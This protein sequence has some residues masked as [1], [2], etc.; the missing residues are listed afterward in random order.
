MGLRHAAPPAAGSSCHHLI[1]TR[2]FITRP[3]PRGSQRALTRRVARVLPIRVRLRLFPRFPLLAIL[4]LLVTA[5]SAGKIRRNDDAILVGQHHLHPIGNRPRDSR[6]PQHHQRRRPDLGQRRTGTNHRHHTSIDHC[7]T[8][9]RIY[10]GPS[11]TCC[12]RS[13]CRQRS[14][15][16][17][18]TA[19]DLARAQPGDNHD[20]R[21]IG[22]T[23][24]QLTR[25]T[26]VEERRPRPTR[27]EVARDGIERHPL[28][29]SAGVQLYRCVELRPAGLQC[30]SLGN[31]TPGS[32][33]RRWSPSL[34]ELS[35]ER[36]DCWIE[37]PAGASRHRHHLH[38]RGFEVLTHRC[39][40]RAGSSIESRQ[41]TVGTPGRQHIFPCRGDSERLI[42]K[43][44][45]RISV[46]GIHRHLEKS[47]H[48]RT[49]EQNDRLS[50]CP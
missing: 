47:T 13:R 12:R 33:A 42:G 9:A 11:L 46:P 3:H 4:P 5:R 23:K 24:S 39:P 29:N 45:R 14:V 2:T 10:N 44:L 32:T 7:A 16:Q 43:A 38:Q 35:Y 17:R 31:R 30:E 26:E 48:R 21:V 27:H 1:P 18:D 36:S 6:P 50:R 20:R 37:R 49:P 40:P 19:H 15:T 34:S 28:A 8:T 22:E 41:L 25:S